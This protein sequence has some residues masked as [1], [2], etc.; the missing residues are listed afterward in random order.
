MGSRKG[1]QRRP[2][3]WWQW[4]VGVGLLGAATAVAVVNYV[5]GIRTL[6]MVRVVE[7]RGIEVSPALKHAEVVPAA[8]GEL[9]GYNVLFVTF[10][11]MKTWFGECLPRHA[12]PVRITF[13][14]IGATDRW[15]RGGVCG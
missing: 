15:K 6:P 3:A 2:R 8:S 9:A 5:P 11:D 4:V 7:P 12:Q 14:K 13:A 10:E 1:V